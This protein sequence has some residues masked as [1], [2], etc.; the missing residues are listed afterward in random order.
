MN[1]FNM[2]RYFLFHTL[3]VFTIALYPLKTSTQL[4]STDISNTVLECY[5]D[6]V[7]NNCSSYYYGVPY[8]P[9]PECTFAGV[10]GTLPIGGVIVGGISGIILPGIGFGFALGYVTKIFYEKYIKNAT[11][12]NMLFN[13]NSNLIQNQ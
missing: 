1:A 5:C 10:S 8:V 3:I 9:F 11:T 13:E 4:F 7:R 6:C 12:S 2:I